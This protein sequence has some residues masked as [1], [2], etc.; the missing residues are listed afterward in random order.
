MKSPARAQARRGV[1]GPGPESGGRSPANHSPDQRTPD[2]GT[3]TRPAQLAGSDQRRYG[4]HG[5]GL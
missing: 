5:M 3:R 1:S 2:H 4:S